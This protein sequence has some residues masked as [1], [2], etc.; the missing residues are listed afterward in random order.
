MVEHLASMQ[1][2]LSS[3]PSMTKKLSTQEDIP[4]SYTNTTPFHVLELSICRILQPQMVPEPIPT[5]SYTEGQLYLGV[6]LGVCY[7]IISTTEKSRSLELKLLYALNPL[8][9]AE[10]K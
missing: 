8:I 6:Y 1:K 7:F 4:R 5:S 2:A 9:S 3:M 10:I